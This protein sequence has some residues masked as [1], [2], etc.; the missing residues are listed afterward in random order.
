[1]KSHANELR[2]RANQMMEGGESA[3]GGL[4]AAITM[5]RNKKWLAATFSLG[6]FS[7]L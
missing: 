7:S 4:T 3:G 6:V 5:R 1:M 2:I